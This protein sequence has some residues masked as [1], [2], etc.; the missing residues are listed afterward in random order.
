M[1]FFSSLDLITGP[2]P[3]AVA[4]LACLSGAALLLRRHRGWVLSVVCAAV[5]AAGLAWAIN[6]YMVHVANATAYDLP[7]Q[8][9]TWIGVGVFAVLLMVLHLVSARWWRKI[10]AP[11]AMAM[12]VVAVSMQVNAYYGAYRTVGASL[13][14]ALMIPR[15]SSSFTILTEGSGG[16]HDASLARGP[17]RGI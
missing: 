15:A 16:G 11:I 6:W 8:V 7:L 14:A 12:I 3:L 1:A 4:V 17:D 10:L 2:F 13:A 9:I 5:L